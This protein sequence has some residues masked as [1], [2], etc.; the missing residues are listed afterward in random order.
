MANLNRVMLMG[1]ITRDIELKFTPSKTAIAEFG[2][3]VNRNWTG[4]DGTKQEEVTFVDCVA[5][6]KSAET[7]GTYKRKGDPL[8]V[9][10]RLKLDQ[11]EAQDGSKRSKLRVIV[12][13]FQFLNRSQGNA[14]GG[15]EGEQPKSQPAAPAP[16]MEE[17][18]IPF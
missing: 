2:L 10:G 11:W 1:N 15:Y 14:G 9:E 3:A 17:A 5:F 8:F 6:G 16:A 18:D 4:K 7:L 13:G 12:E